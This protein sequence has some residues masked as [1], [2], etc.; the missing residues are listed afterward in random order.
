MPDSGGQIV[1]TNLTVAAN[2]GR[3]LRV[4]PAPTAGPTYL[5]NSILFGNGTDVPTGG[6]VETANL[7]GVDPLFT[8]PATG[9]F[10]LGPGS[11]GINAGSATPPGGLGAQSLNGPRVI[12]AAVD[13]GAY[14]R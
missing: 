9:D 1:L 13:I 14:E 8:N 11:L 5:S 12:G 2:V 4:V 7:V 6:P 10:T 3:A